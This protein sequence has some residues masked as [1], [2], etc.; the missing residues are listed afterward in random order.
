[1]DVKSWVLGKLFFFEM[2]KF[3][4]KKFTWQINE[5][6]LILK[7]EA[8]FATADVKIEYKTIMRNEQ[9]SWFI[10]DT[11]TEK[12]NKV[13]TLK[14]IWSITRISDAWGTGN[15]LWETCQYSGKYWGV[16]VTKSVTKDRTTE[17]RRIVDDSLI[18]NEFNEV[19]KISRSTLKHL[20]Q[21]R[22]V[23]RTYRVSV[24]RRG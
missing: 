16:V 11:E 1:M 22:E 18:K 7:S 12:G 3:R 17:E 19:R 24:I 2:V 14:G 13:F 9:S 5:V 6:R 21:A 4:V 15:W 10:M 20:T 23:S 8:Y